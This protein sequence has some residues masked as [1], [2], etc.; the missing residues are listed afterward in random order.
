MDFLQTGHSA[1]LADPLESVLEN[2]WDECALGKPK[3][4]KTSEY[5]GKI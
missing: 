5:A 4:F 1:D 2:E 3:L